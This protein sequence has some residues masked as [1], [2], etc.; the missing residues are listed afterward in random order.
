MRKIS[1]F[2]TIYAK[3]HEMLLPG[4][5]DSSEVDPGLPLS[6]ITAISAN[7][8]GDREA[9]NRVSKSRGG[10]KSGCARSFAGPA[11]SSLRLVVPNT[12]IAGFFTKWPGP[13]STFFKEFFIGAE[14]SEVKPVY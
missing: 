6:S 8:W 4:L 14:L 11:F 3:Q 5:R 12:W 7:T 1:G 13:N 2:R 9:C 10:E